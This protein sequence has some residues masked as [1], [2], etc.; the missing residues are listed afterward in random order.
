MDKLDKQDLLRRSPDLRCFIDDHDDISTYLDSLV[1]WCPKLVCVEA[2]SCTRL[3]SQRDDHSVYVNTSTSGLRYINM[4]NRSYPDQV[5]RQIVKNQSTLEYLSVFNDRHGYDW[6][7]T[8]GLIRFSNLRTLIIVHNQFTAESLAAMLNCCSL[9]ETLK[10]QP[11]HNVISLDPAALLPLR[12]M[13]KLRSLSCDGITFSR[14]L[15]LLTF[16]EWFPALETL[17]I[18]MLYLSP[19]PPSNFEYPRKL[20]HVELPDIVWEFDGIDNDKNAKVARFFECLLG[21][22]KPETIRLYEVPA[23]GYES[24]LILAALPTLKYL[25]VQLDRTVEEKDLL[26]FAKILGESTVIERLTIRSLANLSFSMFDALSG[27]HTLTYLSTEVGMSS[28]SLTHV[29]KDG[30][31]H[32]LRKSSSLISITFNGDLDIRDEQ[33]QILEAYQIAEL[34]RQQTPHRKIPSARSKYWNMWGFLFNNQK[35]LR[36]IAI[37]LVDSS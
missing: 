3:E 7:R 20:K 5:A 31:L 22:S 24:L 11:R 13:R 9:L 33:G 23:V 27:I 32:I 21:R 18:P 34:V 16:L 14:N 25:D 29:S 19:N 10:L 12:K 15:S 37:Q 28:H 6:T 26:Q 4:Y 1:S 35:Q 36:N 30:L 17:Y 8:P 2:N